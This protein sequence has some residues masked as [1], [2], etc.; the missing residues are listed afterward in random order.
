MT[1]LH[2]F[3]LSSASYRV[4]IALALKGLPYEERSYRLRAGEHQSPPYLA[5]NPAGLVPTLEID[6]LKITQS[7]AIIDYLDAKIPDPPL[8]PADPADR[9]RILSIALTVACDIHPLN[10]LRV[11][12]YLENQLGG[13]EAS[14]RAWYHTWV[15]KGFAAVEALLAEGRDDPFVDGDRPGLAEICLVPQVYN[16]RRYKVPLEKYPRI[17]EIADRAAAL[18][19]FAQAAD[20]MPPA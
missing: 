16:A 11:L 12:N 15:A 20:G 2:G 4:R 10:N 19:P 5:L 18:P 9:A 8:L 1:V 13:D 6:G 7:L 14:V 3:L 17:V